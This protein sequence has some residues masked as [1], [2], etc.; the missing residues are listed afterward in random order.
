MLYQAVL[1][2][3]PRAF[4]VQFLVFFVVA[5]TAGDSRARE[6]LFLTAWDRLIIVTLPPFLLGFHDLHQ[7]FELAS[8]LSNTL[9]WSLPKRQ[10]PL[11]SSDV[12]HHLAL[13]PTQNW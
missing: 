12:S 9:L 1:C 5:L 3:S 13:I 8:S 6:Q 11:E 10:T 2:V 7:S 4:D